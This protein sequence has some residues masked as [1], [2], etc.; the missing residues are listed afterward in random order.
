[1]PTS[2]RVEREGCDALLEVGAENP[3][4]AKFWGECASPL[5][6]RC[7]SCGTENSL[8]TKF[9]IECAKLLEDA[10]RLGRHPMRARRYG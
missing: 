5:T 3:D 1:M 4:R 9:C 10:G 2:A 7:S 6:R 8:T